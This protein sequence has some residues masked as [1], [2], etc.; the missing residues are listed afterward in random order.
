MRSVS[1]CKHT[2]WINP[3]W[4][5]VQLPPNDW[6]NHALVNTVAH[7]RKTQVKLKKMCLPFHREGGQRA[8]EL[9]RE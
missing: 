1:A 5:A 2:E 8:T 9:R 4:L 6:I 7:Q 3:V